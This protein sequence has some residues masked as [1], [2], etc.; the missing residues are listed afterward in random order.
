MKSTLLMLNGFGLWFGAAL[1]FHYDQPLWGIFGLSTGALS[2][3]LGYGLLKYEERIETE[4]KQDVE[5]LKAD[6]KEGEQK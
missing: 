4:I 2:F 5:E 1:C 6:Q 3:L